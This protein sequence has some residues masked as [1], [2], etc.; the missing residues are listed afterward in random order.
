M[1]QLYTGLL[2]K[3]CYANKFINMYIPKKCVHIERNFGTD[4]SCFTKGQSAITRMQV[5]M[6]VLIE[7]SEIVELYKKLSSEIFEYTL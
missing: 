1:V 2:V 7:S 5:K 6:V 4:Q 3:K